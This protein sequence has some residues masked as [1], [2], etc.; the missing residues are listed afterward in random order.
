MTSK[1][2]IKGSSY[3]RDVAKFLSA[4]YGE[5][6]IRNISGSG[7]YIGGTNS[8]R[9]A[10]L[11]EAMIRH[12]KG[13]VVPPESFN[14][15]NIECKS[16]GSLEFHQLLKE[17]KQL[18]AWLQQLMDASDEADVNILFFKITRRGQYIAVQATEPWDSGDNYICYTSAKLGQWMIYDF[19]NF[20]KLNSNLLKQLSNPQK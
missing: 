17:C 11:T 13:D 9:K 19:D 6:F 8:F 2:K 18:E 7:A 3:E 15:L 20:F 14:L 16:Y 4:H 5:T 1:S 12:A 10:N